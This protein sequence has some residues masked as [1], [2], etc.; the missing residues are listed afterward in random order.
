VL[1]AVLMQQESHAVMITA[2]PKP[3]R[4]VRVGGHIEMRVHIG[5][6]GKRPALETLHRVFVFQ[7]VFVNE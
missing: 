6:I 2:T 1:E 5:L 7:R 4:G 3:I